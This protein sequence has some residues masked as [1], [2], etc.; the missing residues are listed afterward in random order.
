[1]GRRRAFE[2]IVISLLTAILA[3]VAYI[4]ATGPGMKLY[5][6]NSGPG[7]CVTQWQDAPGP[8]QP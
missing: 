1:M 3:L 7:D 8:P 5:C 2:V 6:S 4:A